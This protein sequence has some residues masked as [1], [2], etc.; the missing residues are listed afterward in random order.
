MKALSGPNFSGRSRRLRDWT[1][2][3]DTVGG[4]PREFGHA[5][6]G[7]DPLDSLS[8]LTSTVLGEF[9]LAAADPDALAAVLGAIEELGF[10]HI[11]PRNPF[12]LS[13]GE[14]TIAAVLAAA[15]ARPQRLAIDCTLEQ[16]AAGTRQSL[17]A[18]L[19]SWG[20]NLMIADNRLDEWYHGA[21]ETLLPKPD[22][23]IL[24]PDIEASSPPPSPRVEVKG[25]RFSYRK[26]PVVFSDLNLT[27]EADTAYQLRGPNGA[28]KSTLS[29]ILCGLIRPDRGEILVDGVRVEPWRRPGRFVTYHFQN[30]TFQLFS[31]TVAHELVRCADAGTTAGRFGLDAAMADHPLDLPFVL[32]KRLA[33]AAAVDRPVPFLILDEPSLGQDMAACNAIKMLVRGRGG[34]TISH[35]QR[36][37]CHSTI[38]L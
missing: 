4:T 3:A 32:R 26:G 9:E 6:V 30:P 23:P 15:A 34:L 36:R 7:P 13:G 18:W 33:L 35:S 1:G 27:L 8:G 22:R 11:L 14:Q 28:G 31:R 29:K 25:L 24:R 16:L 12:T 5:Y 17:L 20:G 21:V 38:D 19:S 10:S 37:W 2:L